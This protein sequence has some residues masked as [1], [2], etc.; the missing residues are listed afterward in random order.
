[1][2]IRTGFVSNSSSSAFIL[3]VK[4]DAYLETMKNFDAAQLDYCKEFFEEDTVFGIQVM[5]CA[6]TIDCGGDYLDLWDGPSSKAAKT[7][8][9]EIYDG[10]AGELAQSVEE[11]FPEDSKYYDVI[12]NG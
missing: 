8:F 12:G 5:K 2:K 3:I 10:D 11:A 1:M 4:K 6:Q 7:A 9:N